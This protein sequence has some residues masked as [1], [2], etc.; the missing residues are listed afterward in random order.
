MPLNPATV[1]QSDSCFQML[2]ALP[3]MILFYDVRVETHRLVTIRRLVD[4]YQ[5]ANCPAVSFYGPR[6]SDV[7]LGSLGGNLRL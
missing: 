1:T 7:F 3:P 2:N 5:A 4:T 6:L